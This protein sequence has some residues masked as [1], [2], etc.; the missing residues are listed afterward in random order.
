MLF[1][2]FSSVWSR[3]GGVEHVLAL[4]RGRNV[5]ECAL[6]ICV[7]VGDMMEGMLPQR[8]KP[9]IWRRGRNGELVLC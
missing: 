1:I 3:N 6:N 9:R 4:G 8:W 5:S 2:S 7:C